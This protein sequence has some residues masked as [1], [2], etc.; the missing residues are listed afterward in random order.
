[1]PLHVLALHCD[2]D[3]SGKTAKLAKHLI[4][5]GGNPEARAPLLSPGDGVVV[6]ALGVPWGRRLPA[7]MADPSAQRMVI[8]HDLMPLHWAA[9]RGAVGV[10]RAL[11]ASGVNV[12]SM[13]VDAISPASM[14]AESKFLA[15]RTDLVDTIIRL[16]VMDAGAGS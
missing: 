6:P 4:S 15:R 2:L 11:L 14:A 5:C 13:D 8:R 1:M 7:A 16:L 3:A 10:I 9:E 12:S